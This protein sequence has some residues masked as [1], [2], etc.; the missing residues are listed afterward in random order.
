[1]FDAQFSRIQQ[2]A[3]VWLAIGVKKKIVTQMLTGFSPRWIDGQKPPRTIVKDGKF[4][5]EQLRDVIKRYKEHLT[6]N[7]ITAIPAALADEF[8]SFVCPRFP[9][10]KLTDELT[11]KLRIIL[12]GRPINHRLPDRTFS[13]PTVRSLTH[14]DKRR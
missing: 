14:R 11:Q 2:K 3:Y 12:N 10:Y 1:M 8:V 13:L 7:R 6:A 4:T 9:L 5:P